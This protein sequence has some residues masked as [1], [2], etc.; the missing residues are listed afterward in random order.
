MN[1]Y[2]VACIFAR[3]GSK[4]VPR[5]NIRLLAGKPLIAY[6]I[7]TAKQIKRVSRVVVSTD[8]A[9]IAAI[10]KA[11]GAEV[12]FMRPAELA[13]DTSPEWLSWQHAVR[14]LNEQGPQPL[15]IMLSLPTTSPLREVQD[16]ENCLDKALNSDFDLI[17]AVH[18]AL[19]HP[20]YNIIRIDDTG[21]A[22][23]AVTPP[24]P[25]YRRQDAPPMYDVTTLVYVARANYILQASRIWEGKLGVA[26]VPIQ[27]ALDIDSEFDFEVADYLMRKR[28]RMNLQ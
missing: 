1:E 21:Q 26:V 18:P 27:N 12:P 17:L 19:R 3:G 13:T 20:Y 7:E 2:I 16:V 4:G 23:M 9:E 5:K 15:D 28:L 11:Y 10:A 25:V 24:T 8:D 6:S 14:T 22:H